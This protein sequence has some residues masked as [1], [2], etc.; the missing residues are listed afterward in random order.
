MNKELKDE[1]SEKLFSQCNFWNTY[2]LQHLGQEGSG[3]ALVIKE[4]GGKK[5]IKIDYH[6]GLANSVLKNESLDYGSWLGLGH[7]NDSKFPEPH[8]VKKEHNN[9]FPE[10][11][12]CY[13]GKLI[14][15]KDL[16]WKLIK[17]G[18]L[19]EERELKKID[20]LVILSHLL[21]SV[22]W[23]KEETQEENFFRGFCYLAEK[24]KGT[25]VVTI[26]TIDAIYAYRDPNGR[27]IL[28]IGKH[29]E[30]ELTILASEDIGFYN[31]NIER[32][33]ELKG[34]EA[35]CLKN[36]ELVSID[37]VPHNIKTKKCSF[38]SSYFSDAS[39][40]I[41]NRPV[42][43]DRMAMGAPLA[44]RDIDLGFIP[45]YAFPVLYSGLYHWI[46]YV[47]EFIRQNNEGLINKVPHIPFFLARYLLAL[48]SFLPPELTVRG[49]VANQKIIPLIGLSEYR[50]LLADKSVKVI[51]DSVVSGL[52]LL[53]DLIPKIV[54]VGF[55]RE[56]IHFSTGNPILCTSCV[57]SKAGRKREGLMAYDVRARRMLTEDKMARAFGIGSFRSNNRL[58]YAEAIG[59]PLEDMCTECSDPELD[60]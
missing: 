47:D 50:N 51:D 23:K 42:G 43:F 44:K 36:G 33:G 39:S 46:G 10:F 57:W 18:L 38:K 8:L 25:C 60:Y 15:R 21:V 27:D 7:T 31:Q 13:S 58:D 32:K 17:N 37:I 35:V 41:F 5:N 6:L 22:G 49:N 59:M 24:V 9:G 28:I 30:K 29:K 54:D 16:E 55:R 52:Q 34:G 12:I 19:E 2:D 1:R 48:R 40:I 53:S 3:I 26:M 56:N 20:D 11:A 14:N 45:D 4:N